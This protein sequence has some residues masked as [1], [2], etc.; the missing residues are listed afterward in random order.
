[1]LALGKAFAETPGL[2]ATVANPFVSESDKT[3]LLITAVC[4]KDGKPGDL[5]RFPSPAGEE[6][7]YGH[8]RR[9]RPG[10]RR[11]V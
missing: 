8:D 4:G 5:R 10:I 9:H 6:K 11:P 1:M 3:T 7:A 2:S